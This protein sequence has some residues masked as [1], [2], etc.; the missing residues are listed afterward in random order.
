[1]KEP[2]LQSPPSISM[3]NP[4]LI[5]L[6]FGFRGVS[7]APLPLNP[8]FPQ[9]KEPYLHSYSITMSGVQIRSPFLWHLSA[10][11]THSILRP[12]V[13][14]VKTIWR[15][16]MPL[17]RTTYLLPCIFKRL[18][19]QGCDF[20]ARI[21]SRSPLL[22]WDLGVWVWSTG[23]RLPLWFMA[24]ISALFAVSFPGQWKD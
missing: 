12:A 10:I 21:R 18:S 3:L 4:P 17:G 13:S 1:M 5:P 16:R 9:P 6:H 24:G 7:P 22:T 15:D 2:N 23:R 20:G 19:W 8:L 11:V 14:R